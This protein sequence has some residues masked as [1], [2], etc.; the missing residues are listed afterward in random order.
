MPRNT[1]N[2]YQLPPQSYGV[3]GEIIISARYNTVLD[4]FVQEFNSPRPVSAGG[5]GSTNA[6]GARTALSVPSIA[7]LTALSNTVTGLGNTKLNI[8]GGTLTGALTGTTASFSGGVTA[9]LTGSATTLATARAFSLSGAVTASEVNFNG[10]GAVNLVTSIADGGLSIAKTSGLQTALNAKLDVSNPT[11]TGVLTGTRASFTSGNGANLSSTEH[12][13]QIGPTSGLNLAFDG[14]EVMARN[15]GAASPLDLN[16]LG[17]D[18]RINGQTAYHAGNLDLSTFIRTNEAATVSPSGTTGGSGVV[19]VG[20]YLTI[21]GRAPNIVLSD[22]SENVAD[23]V[24]HSNQGTFT[25]A[26]ENSDGGYFSRFSILNSG[27]A[28]IGSN[29]IFHAGNFDPDL[30]LDVSAYTAADV[31]QKLLTVDTDAAGINATTV[32][33]RA[34]SDAP[35][36]QTIALRTAQG[37]VQARTMRT[38][39]ADQTSGVLS[40]AGIAFRNNSGSDNSYRIMTGSAFVEWLQNHDGSGSGIDADLLDGHEASDFLSDTVP[41]FLFRTAES[42]GYLRFS[43][44]SPTTTGL[45]SFHE[46]G[47][48]R[49]GFIGFAS[50]ATNQIPLSSENGYFYNFTQQPTIEGNDIFHAGNFNPAL[51]ANL[52]SPAFTGNPTAPTQ[53]AANNSTRLATTAFVQG[54]I[55]TREPTLN[56]DQ[57]RPT[58]ISTAAPSGGADGDVW[59]QY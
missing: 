57:K 59:L 51:K 25:I 55:N 3:A 41:N 4:D 10:S 38:T 24:I 29:L 49:A 33:N 8:S 17:G 26:Q 6:E 45:L 19:G 53:A 23:Y 54:R 43:Q 11:F 35:T 21:S 58:T 30:K 22:V 36:P 42:V 27:E 1:Q 5:T 28:Q 16:R 39:F 34:L 32:Q 15:N 2:I 47:G 9:N 13:F 14:G 31:L 44:G 20:E 50:S 56:E 12:G 48:T 40:T 18:V 37:D 7:D 46:P 52:A